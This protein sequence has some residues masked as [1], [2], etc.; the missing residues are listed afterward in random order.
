MGAITHPFAT[1]RTV[2]IP[3]SG[4]NYLEDLTKTFLDRI[5]KTQ[6]H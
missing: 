5:A 4:N 2:L 3:Y 1:P 6:D